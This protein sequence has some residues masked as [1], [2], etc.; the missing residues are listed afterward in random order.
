MELSSCTEAL[1]LAENGI[2]ECRAECA[3]R[4]PFLQ[5]VGLLQDVSVHFIQDNPKPNIGCQF[6]PTCFGFRDQKRRPV[7]VRSLARDR[8]DEKDV[9]TSG[10]GDNDDDATRSFLAAFR[11]AAIGLPLPKIMIVEDLPR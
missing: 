3:A 11:F 6:G 4:R 10:V 2:S 5:R 8:S 7:F 1:H 9:L